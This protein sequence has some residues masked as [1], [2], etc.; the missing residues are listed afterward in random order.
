MS[1][2]KPES[3]APRPDNND[4]AKAK[5]PQQPQQTP[6]SR[7]MFS[8]AL[9][10]EQQKKR[11][12][13]LLKA[14]ATGNRSALQ[15]FAACHSSG[16]ASGVATARLADAQLVI[17]RE[18]GFASWPKLKTHC[19][20]LALRKKQI[21]TSTVPRLDSPQTLHL[22]CGSDIRHA[23]EI[24][25]F[26]G[27]FH[28]FSDPFCQGPLPDLPLEGFLKQRADFITSAYGL[29]PEDTLGRQRQAYDGLDRLQ[30][31]S[32]VVLWFEHDSYDQLILAFL[33]DYIAR[34]FP[35][36]LSPVADP[37]STTSGNGPSPAEG[38]PRFELICVDQVPGLPDFT[39]LGQLAPELL[40]WLWEN[41]REKITPEQL[42][43]GTRVWNALRQPTPQ[44]LE[45]LVTEGTAAI[46]PM[47]AALKRHLQELPD[48]LTGLSLTQRLTLEIL[49]QDGPLTGGR[50]FGQLMREREPLPYLGDLMYWHELV[51]L[52]Q[53]AEPLLDDNR[54]PDAPPQIW[55]DRLIH[56]TQC[57]R[58]VL[59]GKAN[60]LDL[61]SR[62][63]WV[64]GIRVAAK[65]F[66]NPGD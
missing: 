47:A 5:T 45:T 2:Q 39:G 3:P 62:D 54:D 44:A 36:L 51:M 33:L 12:K 32:R 10:L 53:A 16:H 31:Y 58:D 63:R 48:P 38:L 35:S 27:A 57:G 23:L 18:A 14:F 66:L 26:T 1:S 29:D 13:D 59:A 41:R 19:D 21:A 34:A 50:L 22:R 55:P 43:L 49:D 65:G 46:P 60:Y 8:G 40:I 15:R 24:A 17:A 61:T 25:G 20:R 56:I 42:K 4:N 52:R 11:A 37:D 28:E 6:A 64:G 7:S 9:N 30:D